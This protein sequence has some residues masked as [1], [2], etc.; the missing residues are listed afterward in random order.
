M[1]VGPSALLGRGHGIPQA[2]GWSIERGVTWGAK[3]LPPAWR[4]RLF[5]VFQEDVEQG[6]AEDQCSDLLSANPRRVHSKD[7][8]AR[9]VVLGIETFNAL[10]SKAGVVHAVGDTAAC[11]ADASAC[12][13]VVTLLTLVFMLLGYGCLFGLVAV[14]YAGA[15][16]QSFPKTVPGL[17]MATD[18]CVGTA[19][20]SA[21]FVND[22]FEAPMVALGC[23]CFVPVSVRGGIFVH[24]IISNVR[25][26]RRW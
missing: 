26:G 6:S 20:E 25:K 5:P 23:V 15:C 3:R 7:G 24:R 2:V 8:G 4:E 12:M 19:H 21:L 18:A 22:H 14:K 13:Q 16:S 9:D 10:Q 1:N 17:V 11:K